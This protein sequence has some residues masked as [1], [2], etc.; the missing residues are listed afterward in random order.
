[1]TGTEWRRKFAEFENVELVNTSLVKLTPDEVQEIRD[2]MNVGLVDSYY[3]DGY[4]YFVDNDGNP[5]PWH[6]FGNNRNLDLTVPYLPC[7]LH[8]QAAWESFQGGYQPDPNYPSYDGGFGGGYDG[9]YGGG[10]ENGYGN[11]PQWNEEQGVWE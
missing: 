5:L 1:M 10:Y 3:N 6:G 2:A 4:V 8:T 9:G 11:A 7:P